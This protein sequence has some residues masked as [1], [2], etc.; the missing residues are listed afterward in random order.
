MKRLTE[1]MF[2]D[3]VFHEGV[4]EFLFLVG[5]AMAIG[6]LH[7]ILYHGMVY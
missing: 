2:H 3:A 5:L 1:D 6:V 7:R 4:R